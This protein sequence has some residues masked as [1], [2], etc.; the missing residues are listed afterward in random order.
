[1]LNVDVKSLP[2][3]NERVLLPEADAD[4]AIDGRLCLRYKLPC[5]LCVNCT[6]LLSFH[7]S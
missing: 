3:I 7:R 4:E 1:M 2:I 5:A 6:W